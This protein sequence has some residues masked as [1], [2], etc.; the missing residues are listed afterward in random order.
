MFRREL[1]WGACVV[2]LS[3]V[4]V[5]AAAQSLRATRVL[6]APNV[7]SSAQHTLEIDG[8]ARLSQNETLDLVLPDGVFQA[9]RVRRRAQE[10]G[11]YWEGVIHEG[12]PALLT[13]R[14]GGLS[15]LIDTPWARYEIFAA[16]CSGESC[17]GQLSTL[18]D[19]LFPAC[20][21]AAAGGGTAAP[22]PAASSS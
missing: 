2:G 1:R 22:S 11:F 10:G 15:G 7:G 21:T 19:D 3:L 14:N 4:A 13:Y 5:P 20:E 6:D 8:L 18:D 16:D 17:R 12:W 9:R